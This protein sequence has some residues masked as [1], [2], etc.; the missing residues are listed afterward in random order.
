MLII[1]EKNCHGEELLKKK[2][3]LLNYIYNFHWNHHVSDFEKFYKIQNKDESTFQSVADDEFE[4]YGSMSFSSYVMSTLSADQISQNLSI[5]T[6]L[7]MKSDLSLNSEIVT[8]FLIQSDPNIAIKKEKVEE[9]LIAPDPHPQTNFEENKNEEIPQKPTMKD[10]PETKISPEIIKI[11]QDLTQDLIKSKK[12]ETHQEERMKRLIKNI[13]NMHMK[14]ILRRYSNQNRT[15][16]NFQVSYLFLF[17]SLHLKKTLNVFCISLG[18]YLAIWL[19]SSSE[20]GFTFDSYFLNETILFLTELFCAGITILLISFTPRK[21]IF[22]AS[23]WLFFH[24]SLFILFLNYLFM[25]N[26]SGVLSL[27]FSK[28][29]LLLY[30]LKLIQHSIGPRVPQ[31]YTH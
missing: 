28:P 16:F 12:Q 13:Q 5:K 24:F 6:D 15:K 3:H 11:D 25:T 30:Q 21:P 10:S 17:T 23:Q 29:L 2:S 22:V 31:H 1:L 26:P 19:T 14:K 9:D 8:P 18:V 4:V 7:S 20:M 27:Y